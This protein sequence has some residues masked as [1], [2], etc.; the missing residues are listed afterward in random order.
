MSTR[1]RFL[2]NAA[3]MLG[4]LA[5]SR[6]ASAQNHSSA[7]DYVVIGAGSSG[8]V[9][10]NRLSADPHTRV[11]LVEAGGP[12]V[13]P[14]IAVPGK[15]TSLMGTAVDWNYSTEPDPGLDGRSLKWPRGRTYGG[16]SALNAMAY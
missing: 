16:S 8:C 12:D 5:V 2:Q 3:L 10:A 7:F 15:W 13:N 1:R 11:L 6:R 9:I 14:L 4:A